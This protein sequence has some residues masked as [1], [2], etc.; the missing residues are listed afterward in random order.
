M[1]ARVKE[2]SDTK[3]HDRYPELG[4]GPLPIEPYVSPEF[5]EQ[6]REKIFRKVW[7]NI[8][9][10]EQIPDTGDYFVKDLAIC[11][12]SILVTRGDDGEVH[13]FHNMCSH[14]GNRLAWDSKGK[15]K[16]FSCKY[17]AWTYA[18]DGSLRHISD[19]KKFFGID[20]TKLGLTP[21]AV[22]VWEGFIYINVDPEP[23][24]SLT[25]YL[26]EAGASFNGYPF[27]EIATAC[28]SW[29]V[30]V[31]ANW[32]VGKDAFQEVYHIF[33]LHNR[34]TGRMFASPTN[35]YLNSHELALFDPH[36]RI[37]VPANI[38]WDAT[39]VEALAK[40]FG[41]LTLQKQGIS[42]AGMPPGVN[43]TKSEDWSFSGFN[44]FPNTSIFV[45][46]GGFLTHSFW[47]LAADRTLWESRIY[48][49]KATTMAERFSQEYSRSTFLDGVMAEDGGIFEKT[50]S[51]LA[52]G[53]KKE[54][55]LCDE[56]LL[57][58]HNFKMIERYLNA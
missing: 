44:C 46:E 33:S 16:A 22:D 19:E 47:P 4:T 32:K 54:F 55:Y 7:L 13:A 42:S 52:S 41:I 1:H 8:G 26:G 2:N 53:A 43:P 36:A 12:T 24:Q 38:G 10:V 56:E 58:R 45:S 57:I 11:Q 30:E 17:H 51:M 29:Q 35:P 39:P 48:F 9:R 14:R 20:K 3:W 49:P 27:G 50:Q 25:E 15:C 31:N 6:E 40:R 18:L 34:S 21:V 28:F 5:F 37:S 23:T